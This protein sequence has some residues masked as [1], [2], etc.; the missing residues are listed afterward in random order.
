LKLIL[1]GFAEGAQAAH[2]VRTFLYP[3]EILH[4]EYSTTKGLPLA[5]KETTATAA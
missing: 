5:S 1:N 4:F 2:A 3:E